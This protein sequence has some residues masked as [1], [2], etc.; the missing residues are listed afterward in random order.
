MS[1]GF[2]SAACETTSQ[3]MLL[4]YKTRPNGIQ[5]LIT[6]FAE[7]G[8]FLQSINNLQTGRHCSA[9]AC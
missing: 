8:Q 5:E 6:G 7:Y 4:R 3:S 1:C 9:N 2:E